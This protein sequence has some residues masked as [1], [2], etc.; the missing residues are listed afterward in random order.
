MSYGRVLL[1]T[2]ILGLAL[3]ALYTLAAIAVLLADRSAAQTVVG[4]TLL[5][6]G[7]VLIVFGQRVER[8]QMLSASLVS[9]GGVL[10]AFPL[11]PLIL[12]PIAA[13][14]LIA[15]SFALARQPAAAQ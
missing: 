15:L 7:A 9:L 10:G 1:L 12:P 11:I 13:T 8:S 6:A 5:G 14:V 3:A 2:R 4:V